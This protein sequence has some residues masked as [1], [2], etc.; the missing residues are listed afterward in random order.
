M[1]NITNNFKSEDDLILEA[2]KNENISHQN[3]LV[4]KLKSIGLDIPQSTLSRRLKK[5]GIAKINNH[6]IVVESR[7]RMQVPILSMKISQPNIIILHTLPG[8]ANTLATQLDDKI[9]FDKNPQADTSYNNLCGTI[10]GDDTV[11]VISDGT[12]SGLEKLKREI[13]EDFEIGRND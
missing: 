9:S 5:L 4:A 2:V 1:K 11:L 10:A 8:H 12:K 6:Y 3:E 13:E 7:H